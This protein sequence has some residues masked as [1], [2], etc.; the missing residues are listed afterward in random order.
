MGHFKKV[1]RSRRDNM[2]HEVELEVAP[3]PQ[4]EEIE[5]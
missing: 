2:V 1:C 5:K 3:E 4:E